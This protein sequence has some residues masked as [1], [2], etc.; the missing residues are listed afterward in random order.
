MFRQLKVLVLIMMLSLLCLTAQA[1][2]RGPIIANNIMG[3]AGAGTLVGLSA[4]LMYYGYD[5]HR[6]PEVLLTSSVYG[7]LIGAVTGTGIG[8]YEI[9]TGSQGTG[10]TVSDYVVGGC[11]IGALLGMVVAIIPFTENGEL[12]SFTIGAGIGGLIGGTAGLGIAIFD[13]ATNNNRDVLLSGKIGLYPEVVALAAP[14]TNEMESNGE[15]L[16]SCRLAQFTF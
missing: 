16:Y 2:N 13:I 11:G 3:G 14:T 10:F 6:N 15:P 1:N 8:I 4:G 7:F 12:E 9:G 5:A